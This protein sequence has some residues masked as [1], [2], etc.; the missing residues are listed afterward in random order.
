MY[1][2]ADGIMIKVFIAK[3]PEQGHSFVLNS[4]SV[5]IGRD[6][7]NEI[8][9]DEP[10]VSRR[11]V[12]IYRDDDRYY[13]EDLRSKN[14]TWI[15]GNVIRS[16]VKIQVQ[17]GV[18]IAVGN[19]LVSLGK[20]CSSRRLPNRYSIR[21]HPPAE[22]A[23]KS[24]TF[25]D[26]RA[27]QKKELE[28]IY[29]ISVELMGSLDLAELCEKVL[30]SIFGCLQ[31]IDSGFVFLL[32]PESGKLKK[33]ASRFRE[34]SRTNKPGYSRSLVRRVVKEGK[35][36]MMPN[37]AMENKADL[38]DSIE[39]IGIKS[40]ICVPLVSKLGTRGAIYLQSV[41]VAH[42]FRQSDLFFLTGLSTPM[43]LAI[44]NALLF[45]KSA[46]AEEK[47][48]KASDH[49]EKE[50]MNRT[51]ELRK[52]KDELEQLSITD[53]LSGLY[54]Y[55]YLIQSL[56]SELR[57][58]IRYRRVLALL[59]IDIDYF[60]NLNDTYGHLCGDFVI[61]TVGRLLKS[62]VRNSDVVARY[63]GDELAVVLVET[64]TESALEVAE[65][66]KQAIGSHVF[67]W[68]TKE[69]N[70]N[71]SIGLATAPVPG[72]QDASDLV[73]AADRALYQAKKA[74]RNTVVLSGQEKPI[75]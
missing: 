30:D 46:R 49:L 75:P 58:A 18:P 17:E 73:H 13:I 52:A 68:Q 56:D 25:T 50:V 69:L 34:G 62:N 40:V 8:H 54:N 9:L 2:G 33:S 21:V 53:G 51:A 70:V 72:I 39:K 64:N 16:G 59:L 61:R 6:P 3:G 27:R 35:A 55:R 1:S 15:N 22:N 31:R 67:Q 12:K 63:G 60:K 19:V 65:K 4:N 42:G 7:A 20:K 66:L 11:H 32:E 74:G 57:R 14:G 23:P 5:D 24:S 26:R 37:T 43:A 28:L 29:D 10:S 44:D 36:I 45:A 48:Q 71:L 41:N 47:L 38:S